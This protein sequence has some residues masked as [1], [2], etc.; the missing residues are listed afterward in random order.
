MQTLVIDRSKWAC[1][2]RGG[3]SAL[4]NDVGNMCCLGFYAKACG[5]NE[6]NLQNIY[7]PSGIYEEDRGSL[8]PKVAD[9][10]DTD[11]T[12]VAMQINDNPELRQSSREQILTAHFRAIGILVKFVGSCDNLINRLEE[13][14]NEDEQGGD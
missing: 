11:W 14:T 2:G 8:S 12:D 1:G 10:G 3:V 7:T 6:V 9:F 13:D 5:V 4:L